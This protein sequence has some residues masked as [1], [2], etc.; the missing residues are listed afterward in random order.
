LRI[1]TN[2]RSL[3][4]SDQQ[5]PSLQTQRRNE[6]AQAG[7]RRE[8][9]DVFTCATATARFLSQQKPNGTAFVIGESRLV[10]ALHECGYA[11]VDRD[12]DRWRREIDELFTRGSDASPP[13]LTNSTAWTPSVDLQ[14]ESDHFVLRADVPGVAL[15]DIEVSAQDGTLTIRGER[16]ARE[17]VK[18]DGFEHIERAAGT[19]LRRF[20]L[21]DSARAEAIKARYVD[22]VLEIEIPKQPR[23]EA[24]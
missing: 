8:A 19:F 24:K 1:C 20:T 7:L 5:Q 21:P 2:G 23:V 12:P 9:D 17:H 10:T 18:S 15:K 6:A 13:A 16:L 11:I 22:G 4:A 14:E 3:S